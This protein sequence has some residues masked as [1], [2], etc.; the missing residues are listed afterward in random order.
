MV[1]KA[2]IC[3]ALRIKR[4]FLKCLGVGGREEE[5]VCVKMEQLLQITFTNR[6]EGKSFFYYSLLNHNTPQH[7]RFSNTWDTNLAVFLYFNMMHV[8]KCKLL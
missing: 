3:A 7:K 1:W 2:M 8:L 4:L 6:P 5:R